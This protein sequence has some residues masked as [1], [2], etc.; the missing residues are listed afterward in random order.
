MTPGAH[1]K[2]RDTFGG[3]EW[4]WLRQKLR[5]RFER[6]APLPAT[7]RC[8]RPTPAQRHAIARV[9]GKPEGP[10]AVHLPTLEKRLRDAGLCHSLRDMI[11]QLDGPIDPK[12]ENRRRQRA[13]WEHF[14]HRA[15]NALAHIPADPDT[16]A[17]FRTPTPWKRL[18]RRDLPAAEHL[19]QQTARFFRTHHEWEGQA[20]TRMAAHIFG[21]S[22]ALDR[23]TPLYRALALLSGRDP[24]AHRDVWAHYRL[25]ADEVSSHALVLGLRFQ[26]TSPLA[27]GFNTFA[28]AGQPLRILLRHLREPLRPVLPDQKLYLCENPSILEAAADCG[29]DLH[30]LLCVEGNPSQACMDLLGAVL[31]SGARIHAH[32][33][34]DWGGLRIANRVRNHCGEQFIP[35]RF[36]APTYLRL[37]GGFPLRGTPL[38]ANWDPALETAMRTRA[39]GFHEEQVT[40]DLLSDLRR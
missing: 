18:A 37:Q 16:L 33:D 2:L 24:A 12:A 15:A 40:H 31:R 17:A 8:P 30:P 22:H 36:D 35:W 25:V 11:E 38:P 20:P 7:M 19:L 13:Q 28:D 14:A 1:R 3:P 27:R 21:D 39:R 6:D 4:T 23:D 9:L 26:N 5:A 34:F 32:G 10:P 29:G